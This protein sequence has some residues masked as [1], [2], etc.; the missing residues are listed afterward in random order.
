MIKAVKN[1]FSS[2]LKHKQPARKKLFIH[3]GSYKTG[4]TYFQHMLYHNQARLSENGIYYPTLG[5][6]IHTP[7]NKHAHRI[8]GIDLI[9]GKKNGFP[10]IISHLNQSEDLSQALISYEGFSHPLA[11]EKLQEVAPCFDSVDLHALLVFR[12]HIDYAISFYREV[13]QN[14]GYTASFDAFMNPDTVTAQTL[15]RTLDYRAVTKAWRKLTG[16]ANLHVSPYN[17]IKEDLVDQI[18][19]PLAYRGGFEAPPKTQPNP[20]LTAPFAALLR[21]L[22]TQ[23][24]SISMRHKIAKE[25]ALLHD[26]FPDFAQYTE[27]TQK[28]ALRL[29]ARFA[30]DRNFL[31]SYGFDPIQDLTIGSN[32]R[33]GE[34][35]DMGAAVDTAHEAFIAH[36]AKEKRPKM[37]KIAKTAWAERSHS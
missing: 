35:T 2:H 22:N 27:I 30:A 26:S 34:E 16:K 25:L 28:D 5:L 23:K 6:G 32:W 36:L 18:M 37:L 31:K 7:H 4:T 1:W 14:V 29:E 12:P 33:W 19:E 17:R 13:C 11:I 10:Q 9:S 3:A 8:L 21:R 24:T 15:N 20:T